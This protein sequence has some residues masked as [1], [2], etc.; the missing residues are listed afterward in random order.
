[1]A[2]N[3]TKGNAPPFLCTATTRDGR[4]CM[5]YV[6]EEGTLCFWHDPAKTAAAR[7]ARI[8][9]GRKH[10]GELRRASPEDLPNGGRPPE[11]AAEAM[12]WA[13]W[14]VPAIASGEVGT[15]VA[16]QTAS[17]L[18]TFLQALDKAELET[19]VAELKGKLK[20]L[21]RGG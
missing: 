15:T 16:N 20:E 6:K 1:M 21:Q 5:R 12:E 19:Q 7:A 14:L 9:G 18:R 3:Q 17:A 11:T 10:Q 4:R 8:R 2:P 13:A